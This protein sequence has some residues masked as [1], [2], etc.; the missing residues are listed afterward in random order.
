[1]KEQSRFGALLKRYRQGAGL[2]QEGLAARAR[3]S[4]RTISDLERGVHGAPH[5]DTLALLTSALSLSAQQRTLL[6]GAARPEIAASLEAPPDSLSPGFPFPPTRLIGRLQEHTYALDVLRRSNTRLLTLTGTSGVGKT[7]LALQ[8]LQDL[9][10]DFTD[11]V[12]YVPLAPI[13]D[14]TLVAGVIAQ[15]LGIREQANSSYASQVQ[16]FMSN[17]HLLLVLDNVEQVLDGAASFVADLLASCPRLSILVTSRTPLR[18]RA[19]Q[20]LLLAPLLLE[21]AVTL[22]Y[23]RAQARQ[24]GRAYAGSEVAAICEQLDCLPLAIEMAAMHLK[25]LSLAELRKQLT[26]RLEFLRGGARDLPTR[27]QTME[28]AI[29]WSYELLTEQQQRCFRRLGVFIGGWTLQAAEAVCV[30]EGQVAA[31]ETILTLAALVDA[32]L[33]QAEMLAHGVTRFTMLEILRDYALKQLRAAGEEEECRRR[34]AAYYAR[35]AETVFAHFGPEEGARDAQFPLVLTHELSNAR[36]ALQWADEKHEAELGLRLTGF[37]RLWHVHGQMSEA[38]QWLERMLALDLKARE[39]G[40][41]TAPLTLRIER[42]CGLG[43][44]LVRHGKVDRGAEAFAQEALQL[45][46]RIADQNGISNAF[47]TL[48][49]IAQESNKLDEAEVAFTESYTHARRIEQMGLM[50]RAL[51]G[52]ADVARM[53]GDAARATSLLEEALT[54]ARATGITWDIPIM[55]TLLGHL[56]RQQQNYAL[57]TARYREALALYR[58]FS[59]PLYTAGCLEG[60]AA[61]IC[62]EGHY[63]QATRLCAAAARLREQAQAP[64]P[65]AE[66]EAFEQVVATAKA[67]LDRP[68]FIRAWNTGTTLTQEE[69]IDNA[70]SD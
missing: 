25:A 26:H 11:G 50:S 41:H 43:R 42:L 48:G 51:S 63:A 20:E 49:M 67:A 16:A 54:N 46:Q 39:Q 30:A 53:R 60:Y 68:A 22:F 9:A 55:T 3:L 37:A 19:E 27:Q 23:E 1:M 34:H 21:D 52:L 62:A 64:L 28:A 12:V 24:A 57:A 2:S 65:P 44:T 66:R 7:R 6:L 17:K 33:V 4:A 32:S 13:R 35:L 59:S 69:A 45:A 18:L 8:L 70:L 58:T 15:T 36:A 47:A 31:E 38:E 29:A 5:A 10:P 40:E 61:T 56:A 14:A